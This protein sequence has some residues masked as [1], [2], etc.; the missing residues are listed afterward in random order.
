MNGDVCE[1]LQHDVAIRFFRTLADTATAMEARSPTPIPVMTSGP[2]RILVVDDHPVVRRGI[3]SCL[4]RQ[5][6]LVVVGEAADGKEAL[7]LIPAVQPDVVLTDLDMPRMDGLALTE[8]VRRQFPDVKVLILSMHAN[9]EYILRILQSGARGYVSKEADPQEL[10][11]AIQAVYRGE[12][13]FS[14]DVA[15]LALQ[16]MV[17]SEGAASAV[18]ELTPRERQVLIGIAEGLS[19]KQIAE[20]LGVG[21]RTV[22]TH[23]QHIMEKLGI[24]TVAGL[25]R[26]AVAKGLVSAQHLPPQNH[27]ATTS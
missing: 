21:I 5:P 23:R 15:R 1:T 22:E 2:I 25:T 24:H 13:F 26:Y 3:R 4:Q 17:L 27:T 8:A 7:E 6:G 12:S 11:Q 9:T 10:L 18:P 19:N 20:R 14:A 16:Q